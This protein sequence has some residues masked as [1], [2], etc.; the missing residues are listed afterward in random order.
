VKRLILLAGLLLAASPAAADQRLAALV[1]PATMDESIEAAILHSDIV[2]LVRVLRVDLVSQAEMSRR[3]P[4][5]VTIEPV[6][7]VKG[8]LDFDD[9]ITVYGTEWEANK[10]R[11]VAQSRG[12]GAMLFFSDAGGYWRVSDS[13]LSA[14]GA[15]V[16]LLRIPAGKWQSQLER[17]HGLAEGV[18]LEGLVRRADL[19]AVADCAQ[20]TAG[21]LATEHG[22]DHYAIAR[23]REALKGDAPKDPVRVSQ[24][25]IALT[26]RQLLFLKRLSALE[27]EPLPFVAPTRASAAP[28]E[29]FHDVTDAE[30]AEVRTLIAAPKEPASSQP[31]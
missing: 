25:C 28:K 5:V 10:L 16:G 20:D 26:G 30:I 2:C 24:C 27:F 23:V 12:D 6:E 29:G 11:A 18:T 22:G 21:G 17:L 3:P 8:G 1:R 4:F 13:G 19:V 7:F 31:R 14:C 15:Q 9:S